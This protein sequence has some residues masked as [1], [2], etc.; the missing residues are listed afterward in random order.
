M[1]L[2]R[3]RGMLSSL[4]HIVHRRCSRR[5]RR[6]RCTMACRRT[7]R[8]FAHSPTLR[9]YKHRRTYAQNTHNLVFGGRTLQCVSCL[10]VCVPCVQ[11]V[12]FLFALLRCLVSC[13]VHVYVN[14]RSSAPAHARISCIKTSQQPSGMHPQRHA[15]SSTTT[16][17]T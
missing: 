7:I 2:Y 6:W 3:R 12:L 13:I 5:R 8:S 16:T 10:R 11:I 14:T 4:S 17:T 1:V 15:A 9:L